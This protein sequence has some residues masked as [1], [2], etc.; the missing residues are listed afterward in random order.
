MK[1]S[2]RKVGEKKE[3]NERGKERAF[4]VSI[5]LSQAFPLTLYHLAISLSLKYRYYLHL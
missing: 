1:E 2:R 3:R 5:P 4:I